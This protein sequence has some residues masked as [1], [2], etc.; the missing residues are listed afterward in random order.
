MLNHLT[1]SFWFMNR[2]SVAGF[3]MNKLPVYLYFHVFSFLINFI[4]KSIQRIFSWP[5]RDSTVFE[6][7]WGRGEQ[8][9]PKSLLGVGG[10]SVIIHIFMSISFGGGGEGRRRGN[11]LINNV[12]VNLNLGDG[13]WWYRLPQQSQV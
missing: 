3:T 6:W 9:H 2:I 5:H 11:F 1:L 4:I 13:C 10:Y 7:K 8:T 12:Y